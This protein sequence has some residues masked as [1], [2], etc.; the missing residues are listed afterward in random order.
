M[1]LIS[2]ESC[3]IDLS[4]G[5]CYM[6]VAIL[7]P[8]I[9]HDQCKPIKHLNGFD[10][11]CTSSYKMN[12]CSTSVLN[13]PHVAAQQVMNSDAALY[14]VLIPETCS[15][16]SHFHISCYLE[17]RNRTTKVAAMVDS[18]A[19][20]LFIDHK[21]ANKHRMIKMPLEH[22]ILLYNIDGSKNEAGSITHKVRLA[23]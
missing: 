21:F 20:S 9:Q 17:G 13:A 15:S 2:L 3:D 23:L 11:H 12:I 19:T 14:S 16:K 10:T 22:P 8:E 6:L 1:Y 5:I 7:H 4:N 18:G